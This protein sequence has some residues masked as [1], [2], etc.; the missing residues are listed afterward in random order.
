[1]TLSSQITE[2]RE[3]ALEK[4]VNVILFTKL[5][6]TLVGIII[7]ELVRSYVV[8]D[9]FET[10]KGIDFEITFVLFYAQYGAS[11]DTIVFISDI[12]RANSKNC[13]VMLPVTPTTTNHFVTYNHVHKKVPC[14]VSSDERRV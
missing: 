4:D 12:V 10:V 2:D 9:N 11:F 5:F 8:D 3:V 1:M 13:A 14:C 6:V 7:I